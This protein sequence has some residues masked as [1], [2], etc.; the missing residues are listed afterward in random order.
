M[1]QI[2]ALGTLDGQLDG[3]AV[4]IGQSGPGHAVEVLQVGWSTWVELSPAL[5]RWKGN[6]NSPTC[7]HL[8]SRRIPADPREFLQFS[9]ARCPGVNHWIF[10]S[11]IV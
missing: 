9:P 3:A 7:C 8:I 4:V 11:R 10:F 5:S 1:G 2:R 6:V